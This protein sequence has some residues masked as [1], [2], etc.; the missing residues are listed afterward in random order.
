[1]PYTNSLSASGALVSICQWI[2]KAIVD[3]G[4]TYSLMQ[5]S[6]WKKIAC[7]Q[8]KLRPWVEG[9]LYLAIG[10]ATNPLGGIDLK[11]Q[12]HGMAVPLPVEMHPASC[13]AFAVVL[14]FD[15]MHFSGLQ[16]CIRDQAYYLTPTSS[17]PHHFQHGTA[18]VQNLNS[19]ERGK[20]RRHPALSQILLLC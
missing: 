19:K 17:L 12:L 6:L 16:L 1:M 11:T 4:A 7:P 5:E 14:G 2:G 13:L 3:T 15:C 18:D 8:E 10:E 20:A 9:P